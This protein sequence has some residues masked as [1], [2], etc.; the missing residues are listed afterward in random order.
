MKDH[1]KFMDVRKEDIE[2]EDDDAFSENVEDENN[3]KAI[4]AGLRH[5]V[6]TV[7]LPGP[8]AAQLDECAFEWLSC[9][10]K[11][12]QANP[13]H[14]TTWI[15]WVH[16]V[17]MKMKAEDKDENDPFLCGCDRL[18]NS[19]FS[20]ESELSR[21]NSDL[22]KSS[23]F[24]TKELFHGRQHPKYHEIE[25]NDTLQDLLM[26]CEV[27][28]LNNAYSSITTTE[29][30]STGQDF[31]FILEE[32]NLQLKSWI[33]KGIPTDFIWQT[34]CHSTRSQDGAPREPEKTLT[35]DVHNV[36]I[37]DSVKSVNSQTKFI[38]DH[39]DQ[40][41]NDHDDSGEE[42]W[43]RPKPGAKKEE[44][45][46]NQMEL[47]IE[48]N[49]LECRKVELSTNFKKLK[50]KLLKEQAENH[51]DDKKVQIEDEDVS[52][53]RD[54]DNFE[55]KDEEKMSLA[56]DQRAELETI[57][58][59]EGEQRTKMKVPAK[60]RIHVI[61]GNSLKAQKAAY[62]KTNNPAFRFRSVNI[63]RQ[64]TDDEALFLGLSRNGDTSSFVKLVISIRIHV[65]DGNSLKAQK[66]AYRKTNNPAFRFRSVNIYRQL[67]DDEALFLGLSRNGDTSSFVKLVISIRNHIFTRHVEVW[68]E[69]F[70]HKS[71][72]WDE[73]IMES[74]LKRATEE[75]MTMENRQGVYE[76]RKLVIK[77][78]ELVGITWTDRPWISTNQITCYSET[79]GPH[80]PVSTIFPS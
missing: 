7:C 20:L 38:S 9:C 21:N 47:E 16:A 53:V 42:G 6:P 59:A 64:L 70:P 57:G 39:G 54:E 60:I 36:N 74:C 32:K 37:D 40:C 5:V 31:D 50:D 14:F 77:F 65:I 69:V 52:M 78:H 15:E 51:E 25:I 44:L 11:T 2:D 62:R 29:N 43:A 79:V 27:Q 33:P 68:S 34:V 80:V 26:P 72:L 56:A 22:L 45:K 28:N 73:D 12:S 41:S 49:P 61:D 67:T 58:I 8:C 19:F 30:K 75:L 17:Y 66:A 55:E 4:Y 35:Q 1:K 48:N 10:L 71:L 24:M 13:D 76:F 23:K 63:Y 3:L 46:P 18:E